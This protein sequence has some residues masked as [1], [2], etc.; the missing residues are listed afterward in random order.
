[1]PRFAHLAVLA[2]GVAAVPVVA[3]EL[4]VPSEYATIQEAI[5]AAHH[6]DEVV[7]ASGDYTELIDFKGK[8]I[9]LRSASPDDPT[10]VEGTRFLFDL[11]G[12]DQGMLLVSGEGPDTIVD[13]LTLYPPLNLLGS[14]FTIEGASPTFRRCAWRSG[15]GRK[16]ISIADGSPTFED[17]TSATST[18]TWLP[19]SLSAASVLV[20]DCTIRSI[21]PV[22][23][24]AHPSTL[25][26]ERCS[27]AGLAGGILLVD[28]SANPVPAPTIVL[29]TCQFTEG[30]QIWGTIEP[31]ASLIARNCEF[32]TDGVTE[33]SL[34]LSMSGA[35]ATFESC[36]FGPQDVPL[37]YAINPYYSHALINT[38]GQTTTEFLSC[39][40]EQV[41][42]DTTIDYE[43][44]DPGVLVAT[45]GASLLLDHCVFDSVKL[46]SK[47]LIYTQDGTLTITS[48]DVASDV[49]LAFDFCHLIGIKDSETLI[50]DS[51]LHWPEGVDCNTSVTFWIMPSLHAEGGST[52]DRA[53]NRWSRST[54]PKPGRRT[55][56]GSGSQGLTQRC[57]LQTSGPSLSM[58]TTAL[59]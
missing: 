35:P 19:L 3:D 25:S 15:A 37:L 36:V 2:V 44:A 14:V 16:P 55:A 4:H 50:Q 17:C 40:F 29:D 21:R 27:M 7:L 45:D 52:E 12:G 30:A 54:Q 33:Q 42:S 34:L 13:G 1:M 20:R 41:T 5:D 49:P 38:S 8:A 58:P 48:T 26:L 23:D 51:L 9:T 53:S 11:A 22:D 46:R 39:T 56:Q 32:R 57:A 6:G 59:A 24:P 18:G 31:P 10:S 47:P 28:D 43:D